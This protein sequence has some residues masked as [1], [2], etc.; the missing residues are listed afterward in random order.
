M[1]FLLL[2]SLSV[3]RKGEGVQGHDQ[4]VREKCSATENIP[5]TLLISPP[6]SLQ[7]SEPVSSAAGLCS[8]CSVSP[9]RVFIS[10]A[11]LLR[12]DP[13]PWD[14][15]QDPTIQEARQ[16]KPFLAREKKDLG[17]PLSSGDPLDPH[18]KQL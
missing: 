9:T 14:G 2:F 6:S 3:G 15:L 17:G 1:S 11:Q 12:G 4:L 5:T 16:G 10:Q 7:H 8:L 13:A 18:Y